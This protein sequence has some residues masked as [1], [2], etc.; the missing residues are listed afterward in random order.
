MREVE[1][2]RGEIRAAHAYSDRVTARNV[3]LV[4]ENRSL[5]A[6]EQRERERA[7]R[8][9]DLLDAETGKRGREGWEWLDGEWQGSDGDFVILSLSR[10]PCPTREED[11]VMLDWLPT[12]WTLR[13]QVWEDPNGPTPPWEVVGT[14]P[15]ALDAMDAADQAAGRNDAP[16]R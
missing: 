11:G 5:M 16:A 7:D 2:L 8:L 13:R 9:Q 10:D 1:I 6:G 15:Y 4:A 12:T 14:Y 3:E